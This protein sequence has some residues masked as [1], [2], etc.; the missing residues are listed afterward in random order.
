M[1]RLR[2][3]VVSTR[4]PSFKVTSP[5]GPSAGPPVPPPVP[6]E[7]PRAPAPEYDPA[8]FNVGAGAAPKFHAP[9]DL[10]P[11]RRRESSGVLGPGNSTVAGQPGRTAATGDLVDAR[12]PGDHH[13]RQPSARPDGAA[14]GQCHL[15]KRSFDAGEPQALDV[16]VPVPG[17][18]EGGLRR[19]RQRLVGRGALLA[20]LFDLRPRHRSP[21][22]R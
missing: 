8:A 21:P 12:Q 7:V 18:S 13:G 19:H 10:D 4:N 6:S 17:R 22:R 14:L 15:R 5:R 3:Q 1:A 2:R 16:A 9:R 11:L 20:L